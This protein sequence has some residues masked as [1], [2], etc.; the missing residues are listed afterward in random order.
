MGY[1]VKER[2]I[3]EFEKGL[4]PN[5]GEIQNSKPINVDSV[6]YFESKDFGIYLFKIVIF[7]L[8]LTIHTPVYTQQMKVEVNA[9]YKDEVIYSKVY[10]K[11]FY[12]YVPG[13]WEYVFYFFYPSL[14]EQEN[15]SLGFIGRKIHNEITSI[16]LMNCIMSSNKGLRPE[17]C[18][19]RK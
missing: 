16:I 19:A 12:I 5:L 4:K 2:N 14:N 11:D 9:K 1:A 13:I 7:Y 10:K 6:I 18:I 8:T 3:K 15:K 17:Y